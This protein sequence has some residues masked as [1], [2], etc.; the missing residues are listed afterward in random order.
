MHIQHLIS[1][2]LA[3]MVTVATIYFWIDRFKGTNPAIQE[4][5]VDMDSAKLQALDK[6]LQ[7]DDEVIPTDNQAVDAHMTLL[8]Y[9]SGNLPKG[10][11]FIEDFGKRFYGDNLKLRDNLDARNLMKNY[12]SP[13]Q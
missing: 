8:R 2:G 10:I 7:M 12:R 6:I 4:A 5:F 13:L 1:I 11:R 9:I 3:T